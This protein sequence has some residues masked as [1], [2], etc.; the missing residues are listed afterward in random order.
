[1]AAVRRCQERFSSDRPPAID[2]SQFVNG[3][4]DAAN[5]AFLRKFLRFARSHQRLLQPLDADLGQGAYRKRTSWQ[6]KSVHGTSVL[7]RSRSRSM[8]HVAHRGIG[9]PNTCA[10][11]GRFALQ[12][13]LRAMAP[14]P[15]E[16][17]RVP[18]CGNQAQPEAMQPRVP[19]TQAIAPT[20]SPRATRHMPE[21]WRTP[22]TVSIRDRRP[23]RR[24]GR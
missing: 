11:R 5:L 1:M 20:A 7:E 10:V 21:S 16:R 3:Q 12:A 6:A 9:D 4:F 19:H 2:G 24:T 15:H 8:P 22:D 17:L 14:K 13:S 18:G 23:V